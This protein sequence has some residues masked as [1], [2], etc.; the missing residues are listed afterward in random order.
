MQI[1][2]T[3]SGTLIEAGRYLARLMD[4]GQPTLFI[5][6]EGQPFFRLPLAS[7]LAGP[8]EE[9]KLNDIVIE[10]FFREDSRV[11]IHVSARSSLWQSRRFCWTL[12]E[13]HI[14]FQ[15]FATGKGPLG[16]CYFFSHRMPEGW[17]DVVHPDAESRAAIHPGQVFTPR[18]NHANAFHQSA[19][20]P[21]SLGIRNEMPNIYFFE[22]SLM[23]SYL[24]EQITRIFCPPPLWLAFGSGNTWAGIG[25]GDEPGRYL[26]N[27]FDFSGSRYGGA[28]FFVNYNGY[29]S[30]EGEFASPVA[31]IHFG[32][33]EFET[34]EQHIRWVDGRGFG[35]QHPFPNARWHREPIFCAWGEQ[36]ALG[37]LA[38]VPAAELC[39]QENYEKWVGEIEERGIPFGTLVID[40]K[41]QKQYGTFEIDE[42]KWPDLP[43]FI[44]RQHAKGRHVLL[45]VP[46][47]HPEGL[48]EAWCI[49]QDGMIAGAD[50]NHPEYDAF[51]RRQVRHLIG[52]VGADGFKEDWISGLTIEPNA[53]MN[54]PLYGIEALR[55]WQWIVYDEAH[56]CKPDALIETQT[57]HPLFRESSDVLRLNDIYPGTRDV[58]GVMRIRARIARLAGWDVLDTDNASSTTLQEWW[59]YTQA[60]PGL[61]IPALYFVH[62]TEGTF[63]EPT[64]AQWKY[65]AELW[66]RY[67]SD[68]GL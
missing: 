6:C 8:D 16:R 1:H 66:R 27:A 22:M 4:D 17:G 25:V 34:L 26:F 61:G 41:W 51:L 47:H 59:E 55:R 7:G 11:E 52:E 2:T 40:D 14:E 20:M 39:T 57:P 18:V 3:P 19:I 38:G 13:D 9:E 45:W 53:V 31:A 58:A 15:H 67:R 60:Q 28:A 44:A 5:T 43:G 30:M 48:D 65:L 64:P 62:Q 12:H 33:S 10:S 32:F 68:W 37:K 35:T 63:E 29:R 23:G 50:V 49:T 46:G 42:R 54:G 56:A 36:T 21:Q 24:P